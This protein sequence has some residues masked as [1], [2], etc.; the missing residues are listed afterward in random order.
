MT[1]EG[2]PLKPDQRNNVHRRR[3]RHVEIKKRI[4]ED[5]LMA[6]SSGDLAWLEQALRTDSKKAVSQTKEQVLK[7]IGFLD[8]FNITTLKLRRKSMFV[9]K[10][11]CVSLILM[12]LSNNYG[13]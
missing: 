12:L 5:A 9:Q 2:V 13:V 8:Y 1:H 3:R 4:D 11:R 7:C 6:S 10:H